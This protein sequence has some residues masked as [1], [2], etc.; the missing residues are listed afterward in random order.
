MEVVG[1]CDPLCAQPGQS[2]RFMASAPGPFRAEVVRLRHTD[3]SPDG[4]G[5]KVDPVP[6]PLS[7]QRFPGEVRG[8]AVG[9]YVTVPHAPELG[10][11]GGGFTLHA[12]VFPTL[13]HSSSGPQALISK[14]ALGAGGYAMVIEADGCL[15]LRM[16]SSC[17]VST[18]VSLLAR[19]WCFVATTFDSERGEAC[20]Y[21]MPLQSYPVQSTYAAYA[22]PYSS[23]PDAAVTVR[24]V[25]RDVPVSNLPFLLAACSDGATLAAGHFFNG[26]LDAPGIMG[27][28]VDAGAVV[29]LSRGGAHPATVARW[30]FS[31][32][33]GHSAKVRDAGPAGHHGSVVNSPMRAATGHGWTGREVDPRHA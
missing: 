17:R 33:A 18:G 2:L 11:V 23:R 4:P 7:G 12:W 6:T 10:L 27:A 9:S 22:G 5:F 20:L 29:E 1:Y 25:T 13:L 14:G 15:G 24:H 8:V 31:A 19:Q 26:K 3:R 21:Q 30:D 16:G 28:A 32:P